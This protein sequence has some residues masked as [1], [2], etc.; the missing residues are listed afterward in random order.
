MAQVTEIPGNE[1][2]IGA[3]STGIIETA[4]KAMEARMGNAVE[5][6]TP[7]Q[8]AAGDG[9]R[10]VMTPMEMISRAVESGSSV[11]TL[12]RLM[13][14]QERYE[15]NNARKAFDAAISNAKANIPAIVR[16]ATGHNNKRYADFSAIANVVDPI[17]SANG[18]SYRFKTTQTDKINV[19]CVLSHKE[20]HSEETTLS[21]A[22]DS[23]GSK[24]AIQA[25]GSTLTYLQRYSLNAAL[26][27]SASNDDDARSAES[28]TGPVSTEQVKQL[29]KALEDANADTVKFCAYYQIGALPELPSGKFDA[30]LASIRRSSERRQSNG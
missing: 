17:L 3:A 12:E 27:L 9:H 21:G 22:A 2:S 8:I 16:N 28:K 14:L 1:I 30:A 26:G 24:N 25:I 13:A 5:I 23:S 10:A 29:Q 20:G 4:R 18:L 6:Q 15:A 11:E 19:T 7:S